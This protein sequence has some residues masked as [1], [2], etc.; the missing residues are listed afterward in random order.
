M[1]PHIIGWQLPHPT[2][3]GVE[4][5]DVDEGVADL[6]E[7]SDQLGV[8]AV[9]QALAVD[10]ELAAPLAVM[11]APPAEVEAGAQ[12]EPGV[13]GHLELE[14]AHARRPPWSLPP[15]HPAAGG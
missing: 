12:M 1:P 14:P 3:P 5:P 6:V 11:V 10:V 8:P 15:G 13:G 4:I 2:G 9:G 7:L